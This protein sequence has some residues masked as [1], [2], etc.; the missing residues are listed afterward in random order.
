MSKVIIGSARG[1]ERGRASGGKAGDNNKK[2]VSNQNYYLHSKG[3]YRLRAYDYQIRQKL[4]DAIRPT[5][6]P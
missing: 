5:T 6:L 1:D 2:E 4:A 3:W